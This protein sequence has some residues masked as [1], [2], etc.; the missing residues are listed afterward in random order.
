MGPDELKQNLASIQ[1]GRLVSDFFDALQNR[2]EYLRE[3]VAQLI[4]MAL[5]DDEQTAKAASRAIFASLVERLADSFD[6][7]AVPAYNRLLAQ[8]IERCRRTGRGRE[9]DLSLEGFGLRGEGDLLARA[10]RLRRVERLS[11]TKGRAQ[12]V[13][14]VIALSRVTIGA[15]VAVTSVII[16]RVKRELPG[17]EIVLVGGGKAVE[18]FGGDPRLQ[19]CEVDYR[20]TGNALERLMSWLDVLEVV[21]GLTKGMKQ[22]EF[23]V[24]D[25]DSRLSQLG[26]LPVSPAGEYL[27]FPSREFGAATNASLAELVSSW[28]DV[29]FGHE[30]KL[31]P[32]I[33]LRSDDLQVAD[34]VANRLKRVAARPVVTINF[35]VGG[36]DLKRAGDHFERSLVGGLVREGATVILDKGAGEDEAAR[37]DAVIRE[38]LAENPAA[39]AVEADEE[40]I[41]GLIRSNDL[42]AADLFVWRGRIGLLAALIGRSDLYIGYDSAGQHIAAALGVPCIDVFAGFSSPRMLDRWRPTGVAASRVIAVERSRGQDREEKALAEA[43]AGARTLLRDEDNHS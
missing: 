34:R 37:A 42:S 2:G 28:L 32:G 40:S 19:F 25:P 11:L 20:R 33:S 43:M 18:L 38:A 27:F 23:L 8:L 31:L 1:S 15:D 22:G 16:E 5:S 30:E 14:R 10:E 12:L 24:I 13:R 3:P 35:G 36:N 29:L 26:L 39:R 17:A 7:A 41:E 21:S 4:E 9:I 6:P